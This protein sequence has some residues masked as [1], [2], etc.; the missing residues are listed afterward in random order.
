MFNHLEYD[1]ETLRDEFLRDQRAG[2]PV[3]IPHN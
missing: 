1:A 3:S 2:T